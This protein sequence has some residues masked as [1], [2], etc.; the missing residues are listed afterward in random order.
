MDANS[1][2]GT[3]SYSLNMYTALF[4]YRRSLVEQQI[5]LALITFF[6]VISNPDVFNT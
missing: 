4:T 5:K 1:H 2:F 6:T 3:W